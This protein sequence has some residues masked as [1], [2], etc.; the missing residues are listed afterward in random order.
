MTHKTLF[1]AVVVLVL[2]LAACGGP[3]PQTAD[4]AGQWAGTWTSDEIEAG[5]SL[6]ATFAQTGNEISGTVTIDGSPC[7]A[8]GTITGSVSSSNVTFGAVSGPDG[9]EFSGTVG[10]TSMNGTY[11]V[12]SG[13]CA[14]DTGTFTA[15]RQ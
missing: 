8:T 12:E 4:V 14:G 5:G 1:P 2:V 11:S 6:E 15:E 7:L 3:A 13:L 10:A 9:I